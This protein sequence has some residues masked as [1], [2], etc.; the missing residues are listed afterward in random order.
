MPGRNGLQLV[1]SLL[2][3][4]PTI[5]ILLSSAHLDDKAQL[6]QITKRG[7]PF[8]QKPFEIPDLLRAVEET[9]RLG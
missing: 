9:I 3:I 7:L 4:N 2:A 6:S 1:G 5:P 8:I